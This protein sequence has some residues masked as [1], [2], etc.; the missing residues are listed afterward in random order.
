MSIK[1]FDTGKNKFDIWVVISDLMTGFSAIV[2]LILIISLSMS[3]SMVD[4]K[5]KYQEEY[6]NLRD[7]YLELKKDYEIMKKYRK[8][9]VSLLSLEEKTFYEL[10]DYHLKLDDPEV[11]VKL[12]EF[13]LIIKYEIEKR[14]ANNDN[15][16]KIAIQGHTDIV[17]VVKFNR[18][19]NNWEL[20]ALRASELL[21]YFFSETVL[22]NYDDYKKFFII[23]SFSCTEPLNKVDL[24]ADENR[25]VEVIIYENYKRHGY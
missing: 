18:Y 10:G 25:R 22:K 9:Q 14:L 8:R 4:M 2:L 3:Y 15:F 19:R 24:K 12:K 7:D 23:E 6:I 1:P 11:V 5:N 17:P 21:N 20:G 13:A 16:F